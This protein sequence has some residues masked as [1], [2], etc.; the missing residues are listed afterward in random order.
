MGPVMS[1]IITVFKCIY[2]PFSHAAVNSTGETPRDVS[3][4]FL[5][6]V[7]Q[8]LARYPDLALGGELVS[9]KNWEADNSA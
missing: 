3:D 9:E 2:A 1:A 6:A 4:Y 5:P 8:P 7:C